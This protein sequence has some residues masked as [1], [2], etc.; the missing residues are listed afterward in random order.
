MATST[1]GDLCP[2]SKHMG[3]VLGNLSAQE[4]CIPPKTVIGNVQAAEK[5]PDWKT[6][7]H[8]GKDLPS[9][10]GEESLKVSHTSG[11]DP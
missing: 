9:L 11:S 5:V 10:E 8:T 7:S 6:F 3:M 2:G 4:V 1:Y